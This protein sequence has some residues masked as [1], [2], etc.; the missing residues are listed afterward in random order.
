MAVSL[1]NFGHGHSHGGGMNQSQT[2]PDQQHSHSS[3]S[4]NVNVRAAFIH[5]LGDLVQSIGVTVAAMIIYFKVGV[6]LNCF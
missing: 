1:H 3:K 6:Q 2:E 5:V 4:T